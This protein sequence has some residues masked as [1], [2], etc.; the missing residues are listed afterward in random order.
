MALPT[1]SAPAEN[2]LSANITKIYLK[3]GSSPLAADE[4]PLVGE[5]TPNFTD[6]ITQVPIYNDDGWDRAVKT[7]IGGSV[8]FN[9]MAP[10]SNSVVAAVLAAGR[11][12]GPSAQM[13]GILELADGTY[14]HGAFIVGYPNPA[15]PVRGV[16]A[17]QITITADGPLAAA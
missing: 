12:I 15:T 11:S 1:A 14:L 17:Y 7:G 10:A 4:L 13:L 3:S 16:H 8:T 2:L 9:T 6:A 5:I